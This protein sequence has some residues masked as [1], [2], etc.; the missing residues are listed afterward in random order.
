MLVGESGHGRHGGRYSYYKC[1]TRKRRGS[2]CSLKIFKK[3]Y[4]ESIVIDH[5]IKDVLQDDVIEYIAEK[6]VSWV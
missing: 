1:A 5:T 6:A 3:D 2:K 4:L